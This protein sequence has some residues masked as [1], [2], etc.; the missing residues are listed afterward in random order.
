MDSLRISDTL[1]EYNWIVHLEF[2][3]PSSLSLVFSSL[4]IIPSDEKYKIQKNLNNKVI[5]YLGIYS[6]S[7]F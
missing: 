7:V 2:P 6:F 4:I 5:F 3:L 1:E